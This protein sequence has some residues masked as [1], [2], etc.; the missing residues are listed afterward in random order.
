MRTASANARSRPM[1]KRSASL[2][3][4]MKAFDAAHARNRDGA[5][6][7]RHEVRVQALVGEAEVAVVQARELRGQRRSRERVDFEEALQRLDRFAPSSGSS[8]ARAR[9]RLHARARAAPPSR[10]QPSSKRALGPCSATI[11]S[12][13]P[14][15]ER[16]GAAIAVSPGSRSP[17]A[18]AQPRSRTSRSRSR[19][20]A[21]GDRA[22][23]VRAERSARGARGPRTRASPSPPRW[24]ARSTAARAARR[25]GSG[26]RRA[27]SRR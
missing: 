27:R 2:S 13:S 11:A 17:T 12:S 24:R 20:L 14:R 10:P 21:V 8:R 23:R 5:V 16:I 1:R 3:S 26:A 6:D 4:A 15:A 9:S 18:C 25:A 19:A 7:G 22:R